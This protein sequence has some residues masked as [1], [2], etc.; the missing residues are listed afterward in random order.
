VNRVVVLGLAAI[1]LAGC[2][3]V[4]QEDRDAWVGQPVSALDV[5]PVFMTMN[6]IR[7]ISPDGIEMR[8]YVNSASLG[9][10]RSSGSVYT[11]S[12]NYVPYNTFTSCMQREA[13]C[14]NIFRIENGTVVSYTPIGSGGAK[15]YTDDSTRPG[16]SGPTNIL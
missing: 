1:G 11:G 6:M 8:N 14:N 15:C 2:A 7:T 12:P 5:Q 13:A 10:C 4:R 16:F 3:T 9:S